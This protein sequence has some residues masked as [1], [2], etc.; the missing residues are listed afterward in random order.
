MIVHQLQYT[1]QWHYYK[2]SV[3]ETHFK[4]II[5]QCC[6]YVYTKQQQLITN[7]SFQFVFIKK[8]GQI[9]SLNQSKLFHDLYSLT[10]STARQQNQT[11]IYS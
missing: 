11:A 5:L 8:F 2:T 1:Y 3:I 7:W 4:S 6:A 9:Q 10:D